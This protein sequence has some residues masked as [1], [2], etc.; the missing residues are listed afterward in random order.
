MVRVFPVE[1]WEPLLLSGYRLDVW[2]Q[3]GIT[4][5]NLADHTAQFYRNPPPAGRVC[6][7]LGAGNIASIP[8]L[9]VLYKLYAEGQVVALKLSPVNDYL[10]P[11]YSE[12]F[13]EF[14]D[15]GFLRVSSTAAVT[16]VRRSSQS[17]DVDTVHITGSARSHDQIVFGSGPEA[18]RASPAQPTHPRTSRSPASSAG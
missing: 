13:A 16:R 3:S 15:R 6:A 18:S 8:P 17:P 1:W 7:V 2:M 4:P 11:I 5:A 14:I 9:D 12:I 10:G